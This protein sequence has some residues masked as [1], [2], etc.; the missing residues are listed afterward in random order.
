[1][2]TFEA[3]QMFSLIPS[4]SAKPD[5]F[6]IAHNRHLVTQAHIRLLCHAR[7]IQSYG[8]QSH[9]SEQTRRLRSLWDCVCFASSSLTHASLSLMC[10]LTLSPI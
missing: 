7:V 5:S 3:L 10:H 4:S 6:S 9:S 8:W 1:M 2:E